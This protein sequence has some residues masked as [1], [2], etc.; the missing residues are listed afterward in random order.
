MR[1]Y[2]KNAKPPLLLIHGALVSHLYFV[3]TAELLSDEYQIIAADLPGHGE[4]SKPK[5]ALPVETQARILKDWLDNIGINKVVVIG[6]SYGCTI[7][8]ELA[9]TY[10]ELIEH[11]VFMAPAADPSEPILFRQFIRLVTDGLYENPAMFLVLIRDTFCMG[12]KRGFETA[13]I[14][15]AF[16]YLPKLP[17]VST[18]AL[19][20]R[21]ENDPLV[22]QQWVEKF[23]KLLPNAELKVIPNGPH[24]VQFANPKEVAALVTRF[25]NEN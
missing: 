9:V 13:D 15:L 2:P 17:H 22:S 12:L 20:V 6:H 3:P 14:M 8:A 10:P 19:V 1:S 5:D 11:I 21:G 7:A 16:D 25:L 23:V 18:K 4:S 24:N